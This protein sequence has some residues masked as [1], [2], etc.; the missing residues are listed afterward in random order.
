MDYEG[1]VNFIPKGESD[2]LKFTL[3]SDC[4]VTIQTSPNFFANDTVL[5]LYNS[6]ND[7]IEKN[8]DYNGT[9][10]S[11]ITR[12]LTAGSYYLKVSDKILKVGIVLFK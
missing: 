9:K 10:Y 6:S 2:Y 7:F 4:F 5:Y 8:D 3:F 12:I 11:K 1:E